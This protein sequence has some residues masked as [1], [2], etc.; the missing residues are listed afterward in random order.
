[1]TPYSKESWR[2]AKHCYPRG[3]PCPVTLGRAMVASMGVPIPPATP[4]APSRYPPLPSGL[5]PIVAG[6]YGL[7]LLARRSV[8]AASR[9]VAFPNRDGN[10]S[11]AAR[12]CALIVPWRVYEYCG[13][14]AFLAALAGVPRKTA[15]GWIYKKPM[16]K[17]HRERLASYLEQHASRCLALASELRRP[18]PSDWRG[19]NPRQP[20]RSR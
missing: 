13:A 4:S 15:R 14:S 20:K 3:S 5:S 11:I 1:M 17:K 7:W 12:F 2:P 8:R 19:C 18:L 16:A 10:G 6:R 9:R